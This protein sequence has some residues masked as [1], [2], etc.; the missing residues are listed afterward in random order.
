MERIQ[1]VFEGNV[2]R[3]RS[4]LTAASKA[5]VDQR[6][7]NKCTALMAAAIQGSAA[8]ARTLLAAGAK[9]ELRYAGC[10]YTGNAP[11]F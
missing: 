3:V 9:L 7:R 1:T 11:P 10:K 2:E 8:I 6:G 4:P 5:D